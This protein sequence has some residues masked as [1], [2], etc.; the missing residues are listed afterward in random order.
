MYKLFDGVVGS[1]TDLVFVIESE[2]K[3]IMGSES[4]ESLR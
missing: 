2:S 3:G 4:R 1:I